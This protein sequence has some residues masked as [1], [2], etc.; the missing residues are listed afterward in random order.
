MLVLAGPP[1]ASG[2]T[3]TADAPARD[4]GTVNTSGPGGWAALP[5][6]GTAAQAAPSRAPLDAAQPSSLV[7]PRFIEIDARYTVLPGLVTY[8][9]AAKGFLA[10]PLGVLQTLAPQQISP[11]QTWNYQVGATWQ[12][13]AVTLSSDLYYAY[14]A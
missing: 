4:I 9:Q 13:D 3:G 6:P 2:Q 11:Q 8:A 12:A 14:T 1:P 5:A 10:P 7:G